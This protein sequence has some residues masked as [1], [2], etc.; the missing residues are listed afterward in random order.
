MSL[1][2]ELDEDRE[3]VVV[4][5]VREMAVVRD[6]GTVGVAVPVEK[7]RLVESVVESRESGC[8]S[9]MPTMLFFPSLFVLTFGKTS[10]TRREI[11]VTLM[12]GLGNLSVI[13]EC[14]TDNC[15]DSSEFSWN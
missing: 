15:T 8:R 13:I 12:L 2:R 11:F 4:G 5:D 3:V 1:D 6:E 14:T 9:S 7:G 10:L